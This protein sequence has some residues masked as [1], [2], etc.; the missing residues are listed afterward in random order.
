MRHIIG[1]ILA[2]AL[3]AALFFG[4]GWGLRHISALSTH[5]TGAPGRTGLI[6]L[7]TLAGTGLLMGILLAVPAVSPLAAG[8]PGLVLLGWT[9]FL[10]VSYQRATA[11][12]PFQ[13]TAY[14]A[15]FRDLLAA[16]VLGL[17]GIAMVV[18]LFVPSRWRRA[19][20]EEEDDESRLPAPTGLLS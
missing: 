4:S 19:R 9:A 12:V 10:A 13:G 3:A 20:A 6:A 7:A 17:A 5:A 2:F 16:G 18:P 1:L 14:G 15:G 11:W 8:L